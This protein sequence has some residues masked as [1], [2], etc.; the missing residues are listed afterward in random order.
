M[1]LFWE[2]LLEFLVAVCQVQPF[3]WF[4]GLFLV[5][6]LF[7]LFYFLISSGSIRRY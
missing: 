5:S 4:V 7:K 1:S 6:A 3:I 2:T